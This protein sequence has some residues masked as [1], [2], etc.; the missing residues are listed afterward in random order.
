RTT[1]HRIPLEIERLEDRTVLSTGLGRYSDVLRDWAAEILKIASPTPT[2]T[3]AAQGKLATLIASA[4]SVAAN[5]FR[6]YEDASAIATDIEVLQ[7]NPIT[8]LKKAASK[9]P[10][11]F[12]NTVKLVHDG[13]EAF[14]KAPTPLNQAT[15]VTTL[16]KFA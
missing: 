6:V 13:Y 7:G 14:V 15:F 2:P 3:E 16:Y 11:R 4:Q 1:R 12:G 5:S 8:I 10:E 9:G